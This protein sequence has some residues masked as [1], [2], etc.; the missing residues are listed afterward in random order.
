MPSR[1]PIAAI[2]LEKSKW[3]LLGGTYPI[4]EELNGMGCHFDYDLYATV[5]EGEKLPEKLLK[6]VDYTRDQGI[7]VPP[8][9]QVDSIGQKGIRWRP[10]KHKHAE[11]AYTE[12]HLKNQGFVPPSWFGD[13]IFYLQHPN[14]YPAIAI[15]GPTGNGKSSCAYESL[16]SLER[17]Y[18]VIDITEFIEPF[19]LVGGMSYHP[20]HGNYWVDGAITKAFREGLDVI[21]NEFDAANPRAA[22]CLQSVFQDP[23]VNGKSR[24]VTTPGCPDHDRVFPQGNCQIVVTMNTFGSGANRHYTGR[25]GMDQAT[26]DRF[27]YIST[28]YENEALILEGKGYSKKI[29]KE[30]EKWAVK[31]RAKI[32]QNALRLNVSPRTLQRMAHLMTEKKMTLPEAANLQFFSRVEPEDRELLQ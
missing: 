23:G 4:R 21:I 9:I 10:R 29:A 32:D 11:S 16:E 8:T 28:G 1:Q 14:V 6:N 3:I 20:E 24:Y 27:A 19:E 7:P 31:I 30:L 2:Q 18:L 13:L 12:P 25:N 26:L 5:Y 22:M 17:S 15:V